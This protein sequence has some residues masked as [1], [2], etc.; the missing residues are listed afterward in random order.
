MQNNQMIF[1]LYHKVRS[2]IRSKRSLNLITINP[3]YWLIDT[4]KCSPSH[5]QKVTW[6][7]KRAKVWILRVLSVHLVQIHLQK[8]R[9]GTDLACR[10]TFCHVWAI[11]A[12]VTARAAAFVKS[13]RGN[14]SKHHKRPL[15]FVFTCSMR[16]GTLLIQACFIAAYFIMMSRAENKFNARSCSW[17]WYKTAR[18]KMRSF[19]SL[20]VVSKCG[21][22]A[23]RKNS[24]C[25]HKY[26]T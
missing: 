17:K 22:G 24:S 16:A 10:V 18:R 3:S 1:M 23:F 21:Y 6:W 26:I 8:S 2:S 12:G 11:R 19:A 15:L 9:P 13:G 14:P 7:W 20:Y 4:S 5:T 25:R